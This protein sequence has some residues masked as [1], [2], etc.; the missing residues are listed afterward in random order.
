MIPPEIVKL[1][2]IIHALKFKQRWD[3]THCPVKTGLKSMIVACLSSFTVVL[4]S[5]AEEKAA[6][7]AEQLSTQRALN[8]SENSISASL[9]SF[10][11]EDI[12]D[13]VQLGQWK[14][15]PEQGFLGL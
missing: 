7:P 3:A 6:A 4:H 14:Q 10:F 13:F 9:L 8:V 12:A 15:T 11:F 2:S 5:H 1:V